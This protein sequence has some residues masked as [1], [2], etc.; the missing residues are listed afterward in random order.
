MDGWMVLLIRHKT[1]PRATKTRIGQLA[2]PHA[3]GFHRQTFFPLDICTYTE[4]K[5]EKM[6]FEDEKSKMEASERA[7]EGSVVCLSP[8]S[9]RHRHRHRH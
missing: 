2:S 1:Q 5:K 3:R 8:A 4:R 6:G 7:I 9:D